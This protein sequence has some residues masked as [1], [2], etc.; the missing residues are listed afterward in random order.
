MGQ[1]RF[2]K[3]TTAETQ[4]LVAI[5]FWTEWITTNGD[6]NV[7]NQKL[8]DMKKL[9]RS[10]ILMVACISCE[11]NDVNRNTELSQGTYKGQ[12]IRSSPN[13]RYAPSNVTLT[14]TADRFIGESDKVKYPAICRGT[15]K[16]KGQKIEFNNECAWTT[17]FDWSYILS[18]E[19]NLSVDGKK[20]EMTKYGNGHSDYYKLVLQ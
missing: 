6:F 1:I 3:P 15:Y 16:V 18:G 20:L 7:S 5:A 2:Q 8:N 9:T 13:A 4:T 17:E 11:Y 12:F 14:L 19:F 10:L